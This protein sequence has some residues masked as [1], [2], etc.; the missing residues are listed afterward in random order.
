MAN[1]DN[2]LGIAKQLRIAKIT[3]REYVQSTL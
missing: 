1:G 2:N 3:D